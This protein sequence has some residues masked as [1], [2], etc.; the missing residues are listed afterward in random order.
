M[1]W[2]KIDTINLPEGEVVAVCLTNS[3]KTPRPKLI[4]KLVKFTSK[5]INCQNKFTTLLAV[6]HYLPLPKDE[7]REG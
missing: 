5:T 7:E 4:G 1:T 3:E 2:K 6:T